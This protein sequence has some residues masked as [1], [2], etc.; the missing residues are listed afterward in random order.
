MATIKYLLQSKS[1][2]SNIYVRYSINRQTV[3]KRKTGFII[4]AK[5]WSEDKA[6]PKAGRED[7]KALKSKLEKLATFINDSYNISISKGTAFTGDRLEFQ[8]NSFNN[9]VPFLALDVFT[10]Y[11]QKYIDDAPFKQN[12]KKEFGLSANYVTN[13]ESFLKTIL[14]YEQE[15]G[16]GKIILIKEINLAFVEKYKTWLFEKGY[17]VNY[18]GSNLT[19]IKTI[20][21]DASRNDIEI[22]T[23]LK[24]IKGIS[25]RKKPDE[26]VFLS[27]AEQE[28]IKNTP[29]TK[30][31]LLN[32]RKWLLLGCLIG[33]RGGDLLEITPINIKELQGMK[34]V[35]LKQ[36]KTG[37]LVAIP[38]LPDALELLESGLPYKISLA[39][40][41]RHLKEI[42]QEA[43][44]N[45]PTQGLERVKG[46]KVSIKGIFPKHQIISSHVCRRSFAS[47]F[48]GRIPT[49]ILMNITA[50]STEEM[51]LAYIGKTTYDNAYQMLQ[52]FSKLTPRNKNPVM[53]EV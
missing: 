48:Y 6:Q 13:L 27:E 25:E 33:Q 20:C 28:A 2:T 43:Q 30:E 10:N 21:F 11:I 36:Q 7:L 17:S 22:S 46:Q 39:L 47:N 50:H 41:N 18:V 4:S 34:I 37:K 29:L 53:E 5:D 24:S 38:L 19:F 9:K 12:S 14:R 42:C 23:Q 44:L 15:V 16:K 31:G 26:I 32:A 51:F 52:Y 8:I 1:E 40:F 3:L 35:E 45:T 49:P